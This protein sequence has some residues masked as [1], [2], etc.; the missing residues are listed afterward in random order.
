MIQ[1]VNAEDRAPSLGAD[2]LWGVDE[3]AAEVGLSHRQAYHQ[4]VTG[5]LPARKQAGKWIASRSGLRKH[6]ANVLGENA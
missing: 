6:F 1:L 2:L 3:I 5:R 4:L